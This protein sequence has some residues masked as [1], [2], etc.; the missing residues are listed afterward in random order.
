MPR[1]RLGEQPQLPSLVV[2]RLE[3]LERA[4]TASPEMAAGRLCTSRTRLENADNAASISIRTSLAQ[5]Y[6]Y[7]IS[8]DCIGNVQTLPAFD[9]SDAIA[10][11]ADLTDFDVDLLPHG[12]RVS[13]SAAMR[14]SRLP[15]AP[16]MGLSVTPSTT[17]PGRAA[18]HA[19]IRSHTS[20]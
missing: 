12:V 20:R 15:S 19:L 3:M 7:D 9:G 14:N 4:A 1:E 16:A 5:M 2:F 13:R 11:R 18:S 8:W 10:A 6:A 17:Q